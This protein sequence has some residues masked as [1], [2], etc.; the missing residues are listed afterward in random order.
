[1]FKL[2]L[3]RCIYNCYLNLYCHCV[4]R[5]LKQH[6]QF[7]AG[8]PGKYSIFQGFPVQVLTFT[9]TPLF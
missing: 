5:E 7:K 4:F 2:I 3:Y 8:S 6:F 9:L 1:M